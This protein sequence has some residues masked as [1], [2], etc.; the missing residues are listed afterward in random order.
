MH[1]CLP[2]EIFPKKG[3]KL[4]NT[5]FDTLSTAIYVY[6]QWYFLRLFPTQITN[7]PIKGF[8]ALALFSGQLKY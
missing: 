6:S 8:I 3:H 7:N 2:E 1:I 5:E 4:A